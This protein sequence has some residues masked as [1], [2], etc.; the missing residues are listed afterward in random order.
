MASKGSTE[1]SREKD[2][3]KEK[4]P[5]QFPTS[6]GILVEQGGTSGLCAHRY[7]H[8]KKLVNWM[9]QFG[10]LS[11]DAVKIVIDDKGNS[12]L[13]ARSFI[14][15]NSH[16]IHSHYQ[17][18]LSFL[19]M[20]EEVAP[21]DWP[22]WKDLQNRIQK[23]TAE[24]EWSEDVF[25]QR[26]NF[27]KLLPLFICIVGALHKISQFQKGEAVSSLLNT[28]ALY[29]NALPGPSSTIYYGWA[30]NEIEVLK[31]C[32]YYATVPDATRFGSELFEKLFIPFTRQH[33]QIFGST[34]ISLDDFMKLFGLVNSRAFSVEEG[35][36]ADK[37]IPVL[38][39]IKGK[40]N[41]KFNSQLH[42]LYIEYKMG[43]MKVNAIESCCDI[44]AGE[45]IYLGI[46]CGNGDYLALYNHIP[47]DHDVIT[48]SFSTEVFLNFW[49]FM[50]MVLLRF[51]PNAPKLRR[52]KKEHIGSFFNLP[53]VVALSVHELFSDPSLI[54]T[55]R[56]VLIFLQSSEKETL[57]SV[58][59]RRLKTTFEPPII[60]RL[61]LFFIESS[62]APP[63]M[64]VFD[65]LKPIHSS[66]EDEAVAAAGVAGENTEPTSVPAPALSQMPAV[67]SK[68]ASAEATGNSVSAAAAVAAATS[69]GATTSGVGTTTTTTSPAAGATAGTNTKVKVTDNMRSA[70]YL[71]IS[72]R[73][74][75]EIMIHQFV[76][77]FPEEYHQLA[78]AMFR[79]HLVS[80]KI[81]LIL[82]EVDA[83]NT[84]QN[85][86]LPKQCAFCGS[87]EGK[88]FRC[89]RCTMVHYCG[90][91]CQKDH[92]TYHKKVCTTHN[93]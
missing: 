24:F 47:Y 75:V 73:I 1:R 59:T 11:S 5:P 34:S 39:L 71:Q 86:K 46:I 20:K 78:H 91:P 57:Q 43:S 29:W 38:D 52:I 13:V 42:G 44:N 40:P 70:I 87:M 68:G 31:E 63:D 54:N 50:N 33:P 45:T 80:D 6:G 84:E 27:S 15:A 61:F 32:S 81:G 23:F 58:E 76:A 12:S 3:D 51:H 65:M 55:L 30:P 18:N 88:L 17:F 67:S 2:K 7:E 53:K 90:V 82:D 41:Q 92:W 77:L 36:E 14:P 25:V 79:A 35:D 16:L 60:F 10:L 8:V 93:K 72:E 21:V 74:V 48:K 89:S 69:A 26:D 4:A 37:L 64:S 56:Q 9:A 22:G 49:E 28:F 83:Y 62:F 66:E 19:S 85:S